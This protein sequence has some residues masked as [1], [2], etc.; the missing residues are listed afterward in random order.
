MRRPLAGM[1]I[2]KRPFIEAS[3]FRCQY[4]SQLCPIYSSEKIHIYLSGQ[5][6]H[7]AKGGDN[8]VDISFATILILLF[9]KVRE[10]DDE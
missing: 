7:L 3:I 2:A 10:E 1:E 4:L 5:L 9:Y 6:L 8:K